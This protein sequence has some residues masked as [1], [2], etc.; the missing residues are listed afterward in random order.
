MQLRYAQTEHIASELC[1]AIRTISLKKNKT[2]PFF[3]NPPT[4]TGHGYFPRGNRLNCKLVNISRA[5]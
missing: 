2:G 3:P 1:L 5:I 4:G